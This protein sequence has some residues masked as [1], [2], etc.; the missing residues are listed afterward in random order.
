MIN[1]GSTV[2]ITGACGGIGQA[3]V[4]TFHAEG[5]MVIGTDLVSPDDKLPCEYFFQ[6]D[7]NKTVTDESYA[8]MIFQ[9]IR[10]ILPDNKLNTL[11]NNAAV[12][13]LAPCERLTRA[14]WFKTLNV[15]LLGPFFWTQAMLPELK[16]ARG[17]VI[18]IS[19]I[20]ASVTKMEFAAY[21]TSKAALSNLTRSLALEVGDHIRVNAIEPGAID[22]AM[23]RAGFKGDPTGFEN[24]QRYHPT[25]GIGIPEE[26]AKLALCLASDDMPFMNG[27]TIQLDGGIS[28]RLYDPC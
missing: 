11:V 24:L 27:A 5:Y 13:L 9:R 6:A 17:S 21:A 8:S 26:V 10:D 15:N 20:H 4:K 3:L 7:L 16:N 25:Q 14:D 19:S 18:N 12:Q 2:L 28:G 23:L 22:T 1:N